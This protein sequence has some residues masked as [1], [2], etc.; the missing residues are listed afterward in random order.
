MISLLAD[1]NAIGDVDKIV[2]LM[3]LEPWT[4]FWA[5]LNLE[6]L[7]FGDVGLRLD[8]TDLEIWQVCQ[9]RGLILITDNRKMDSADSLEA[10]IRQFNNNESWPV[11]TIAPRFRRTVSTWIASSRAYTST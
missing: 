5:L 3:Q 11:F 9:E 10:S 2:R 6:L 1:A 7:Y 4:D 8:S